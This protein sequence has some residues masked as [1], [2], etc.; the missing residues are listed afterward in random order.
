MARTPTAKGWW[1]VS[2]GRWHF[3]PVDCRVVDTKHEPA[4]EWLSVRDALEYLRSV[5]LSPDGNRKRLAQWAAAGLLPGRAFFLR[6]RN[7][8]L[9][10][11][12]LVSP[13]VWE[14]VVTGLWV[15]VDWQAGS[16]R[17]LRHNL[18]PV[19]DVEAHGIEFDKPALM[20]LAP[21]RE[22]AAAAAVAPQR[23]RPL[24]RGRRL[25]VG[26]YATA[27]APLIEEMRQLL[28]GEVV[29]SVHAAAVQMAPRAVGLG[30]PE[31]KVRRLFERYKAAFPDSL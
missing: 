4:R 19:L 28:L 30:Q 13:S 23:D 22:P 10:E 12:S 3:D 24:G 17:L 20:R 21:G 29:N 15:T 6:D 16:L 5:G 14:W 18:G 1:Q 25:G 7:E 26:G 2:D 11:G 8:R 9:P 31:S 27:D